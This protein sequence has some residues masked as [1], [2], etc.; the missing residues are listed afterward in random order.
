MRRR[1]S[2]SAAPAAAAE[3]GSRPGEETAREGLR[4]WETSANE[5]MHHHRHIIFI[6]VR[7]DSTTQGTGTTGQYLQEQHLM[8]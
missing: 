1:A 6:R 4:R 2:G 5:P 3:A 7:V 8:A